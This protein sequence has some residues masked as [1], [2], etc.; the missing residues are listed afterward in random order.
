MTNAY[1]RLVEKVGEERARE[2]MRERGA[3][4]A[5]NSKGTGGFA[6]M[7]KHSPERLKDASRRGLES[8]WGKS[9]AQEQDDPQS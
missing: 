9:D 7:K 4:S 6:H 8:R 1:Q 2:V 5:R 3:K